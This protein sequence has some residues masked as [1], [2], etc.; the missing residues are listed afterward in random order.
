MSAAGLPT[1]T[2]ES[3][4]KREGGGGGEETCRCPMGNKMTISCMWRWGGDIKK[5][6]KERSGN[7]S[8]SEEKF[9]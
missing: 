7:C 2:V 9:R 3:E 8:S 4:T 6:D 1:G 5:N